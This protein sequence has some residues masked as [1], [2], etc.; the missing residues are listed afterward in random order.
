MKTFCK[1]K[2]VNI[3]SLEF[4]M[5]A[6]HTAFA[7]KLNKPEF[8]KL[9]TSTG[10]ITADELRAERADHSCVK[11]IKAIDAVAADLTERIQKRD[12]K[13]PPIRQFQRI[14]GI[15]QKLRDLNQESPLQQIYEYIGVKAL[16]PLFQAKILHCQYGSIPGKGQVAGK[17]KIERIL[18]Q[19]FHCKI[20]EIKG[21]V[22]HAYQSVTT[23]CVMKLLRRDIRKNKPLLWFIEAVM[24]NYPE[25]RLII[26]GYMPT[27]L[28]NYVMS[29]V[30]R[31]LLELHKLRRKVRHNMV[32]ACVCYADDFSLYGRRSNLIRAI[33]ETARWCKVTLGLEIKEAWSFSYISSFEAE[34]EVKSQRK[35]G[36]KKRTPGIDMMGFV[37]RRTYTIIRGK[38]FVR[39]R[40]QILRAKRNLDQTGY[41]PWWRA[42]KI[43]SY[44]GWLTNSDSQKFRK[45]YDVKR[46]MKAAKQSV[47]WEGKS[48][49]KE[50][51][52]NERMLCSPA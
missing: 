9:L 29:Y 46:I 18:R 4:N 44:Y 38:I 21:D 30:L 2:N 33:K 37:V 6:V 23:E 14:D 50:A 42:Y 26:G 47:S 43:V 13:L 11:T 31:H 32:W 39:I 52:N 25:G 7:G 15:S 16:M 17:R 48:K 34:K 22:R 24:S 19:K 12:L 27:W 40:R 35:N 10:E 5:S 1:P 3:E 20:D 51:I 8:Q 36:S 45:K 28:F 49:L 41:I